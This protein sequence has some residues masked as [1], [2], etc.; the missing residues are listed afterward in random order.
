MVA[1][2]DEEPSA[3]HKLVFNGCEIVGVKAKMQHIFSRKIHPK[4]YFS[5]QERNPIDICVMA[6]Y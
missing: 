6:Q 2:L 3:F 5:P 4:I 1:L